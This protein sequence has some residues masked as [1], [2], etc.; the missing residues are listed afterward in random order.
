MD[1]SPSISS[2]EAYR[3][4]PLPEPL[5]PHRYQ[6][7]SPL[8]S[9][10]SGHSIDGHSVSMVECSV[11]WAD[12]TDDN[13]WNDA[14]TASAVLTLLHKE[15]ISPPR[16]SQILRLSEEF[17]ER[18]QK[19]CAVCF[20][21]IDHLNHPI[22]AMAANCDHRAMQDVHMCLP[23]IRRYLDIQFSTSG[24]ESLSCP[25]CHAQLSHEEVCRWASPQT[26]QAYDNIKTRQIL[27]RN[28]EFITCIRPSCRYGQLH[29]GGRESPIIACGSCGTR[30]CFVH[31]GLLWHEGLSCEE[32]DRVSMTPYI[33]TEP[34]RDNSSPQQGCRL[35]RRIGEWRTYRAETKRQRRLLELNRVGQSNWTTEDLLSQQTIWQT[36]KPCPRCNAIT[37]REGGCKYMRCMCVF[38]E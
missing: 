8:T 36:A 30:M 5:Y 3:D 13:C 25:L 1:E 7:V 17:V 21:S 11:P 4:V 31:R 14:F 12:N 35:L 32:Y 26:F 34:R 2:C 18:R 38:L 28:A 27:E 29:V 23:C 37:E 33:N 6:P 10:G 24:P 16:Q 9:T 19:R 20:E 15:P 22:P